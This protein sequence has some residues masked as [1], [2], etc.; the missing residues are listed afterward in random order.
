MR[1]RDLGHDV[2]VLTAVGQSADLD[3]ELDVVRAPGSRWVTVALPGGT[4]AWWP[5]C[6]TVSRWT[7]CT[8]TSP[9]SPRWPSTSP[10]RPAGA[11]S[12]SPSPCIRCGGRW[13]GPPGCR[14]CRSAGAG[15]ERP[16]PG[17]AAWPARHV[18]RTLPRAGEVSVVPNLVDVTWWHPQEPIRATGAGELRLILVGRLKKRKHVG[19]FIDVLAAVRPAHPRGHQGAGEHRRHRP[20]PQGPR[21]PGGGTG[22]ERLG[23][24]PGPPRAGATSARCCT[25]RTCSSPPRVRNRSASPRWKPGPPACR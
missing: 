9:S 19:E 25:N 1:Q 13:P 15:S 4:T 8:P 24:V 6:S 5:T 11:A 23:R 18:A 21:S 10:G 16:G 22:S 17:S 12:R 14:R 7:S 20:A 2:T 3:A